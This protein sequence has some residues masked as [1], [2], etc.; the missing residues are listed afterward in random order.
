MKVKHE[1]EVEDEECNELI[2]LMLET[3]PPDIKETVLANKQ[4][5][6]SKLDEYVCAAFRMGQTLP[7]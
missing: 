7:I 2:M 6:R 5:F 1:I 4:A 3:L